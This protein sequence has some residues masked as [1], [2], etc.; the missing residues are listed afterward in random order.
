E[1]ERVTL[2]EMFGSRDVLA[3]NVHPSDCYEGREL[4]RPFDR[5]VVDRHLLK[6]CAQLNLQIEIECS[7]LQLVHKRRAE[8]VRSTG[9]AEFAVDGVRSAVRSR[10][11]TELGDVVAMTYCGH[12]PVRAQQGI[13]DGRLRRFHERE[14]LLPCPIRLL[15]RALTGEEIG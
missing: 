14:H 3:R 15:E 2:F 7:C 9:E 5:G 6:I 12:R 11:D 13:P 10:S 8:H 1:G 4:F